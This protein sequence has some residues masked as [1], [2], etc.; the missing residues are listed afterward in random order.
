MKFYTNVYYDYKKILLSEKDDNGNT[1]YRE[2]DIKPNVFL[3]SK[4]KTEFKSIGGEYLSKL[5]FDSYDEYKEFIKSYSHIPNFDIY[6]D[7][8]VE[9]KFINNYYGVNNAYDFSKINIAYIDI[10]TTSEK[11][12]PSISD[13]EEKVIV[14]SLSSTK[15]GKATFCLGKFDAGDDT[16]IQVFEFTDEPAL[17]RSFLSYF[18]KNYPDIVSGW[19]I[20]FFDFPYLIK[21]INKV[22]GKKAAKVLSPWGILK[23]KYITRNNREELLYEIVGI[24]T[25]DYYEVYK[26]FTYV[27]QESYR[28]D[29][30]A[31]VE[32]G[33]RKL[34]YDEFES[35]TEFYKKDF[36]K[37]VQYNIKDVELVQN[38]E[39]KLKLIELSVAL[40]YSAGVNY[41]D[42]FSQVKTWDVIIYNHLSEKGIVIPP[43]KKTRKN[44]QYA[45][46][47]VK[48][49]QVGMHNYV[50][51]FDLNSM[52]PMIISGMNICPSTKV[53][54][55][56]LVKMLANK[57][58]LE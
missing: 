47:Y 41:Q 27:N 10:E 49:P 46:A 39:N 20:R 8:G 24:A 15:N 22:L 14:I 7:I 34:S 53:N 3:P 5:E 43:K 18:S 54:R 16:D 37:F 9:Y 32:L 58:E 4:T 40:A 42:V 2:E 52:Y 1:T 6:G 26:T 13:P 11:G 31:Y 48:D 33:Q 19:N 50:V 21:R 55:E 28:L 45:G 12:F 38:L 56:D 23:E 44:E 17:L 30:I 29:H 57:D 51:S 25:L 35:I 36:Q